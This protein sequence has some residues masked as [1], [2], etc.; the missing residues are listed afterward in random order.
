MTSSVCATGGW[1][2]SQF[3][4]KVRSLSVV[5]GSEDDLALL[6]HHRPSWPCLPP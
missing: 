2:R 1:N 6:L 3:H 4:E 5:I